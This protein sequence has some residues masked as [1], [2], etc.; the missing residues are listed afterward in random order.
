MFI[1][2][3][4]LVGTFALVDAA[5]GRGT[6]SKG[7]EAATTLARELTEQARTMSYSELTPALLPVRLQDKPGLADAS[8]TAP[9][10]Q[11][12]RRGFD[13]TVAVAVCSLDDPSDKRG[14]HSA[15]V[16]CA[17][18]ADVGTDDA[19]P[20]DLKRVTVTTSFSDR[21]RTVTS[22]S[23][24]TLNS[25]GQA[26]GLPVDTL[27]LGATDPVSSFGTPEE[28]VIGSPVNW[29][30]FRA[31]SST[32][33]AKVIWTIEGQRGAPDATKINATTWEFRWA[34]STVS[35]GSYTVSAQAVDAKGEVGP[36]REMPVRLARN[37]PPAPAS[38][39]GGYNQVTRAGTTYPNAAEFDWPASSQRNI[40]GYRLYRGD[41]TLACPASAAIISV[42]TSCVDE[43]PPPPSM[44]PE[45]DAARTY[46]VVALYRDA[47]SVL[48]ETASKTK[49]IVPYSY[50]VN[51]TVDET[52]TH[53]L[54]LS[55]ST[56]NIG[57]SCSGTASREDMLD[58]QAGVFGTMIGQNV[59]RMFCSPAYPAEAIELL[60]QTAV[61]YAAF[62]GTNDR[63]QVTVTLRRQRGT[64]LTALGAPS[65]RSFNTEPAGEYAM[66]GI[67][68][69]ATPLA[70]GDRLTLTAAYNNQGGC[71]TRSFA[72]G[73]YN[74]VS[75]GR[76]ALQYR[77]RKTVTRTDTSRP[78]PPTGLTSTPQPDGT[79]K[80]TWNKP[81]ATPPYAFYRIYADGIDWKANRITTAAVEPGA[82]TTD[83]EFVPGGA[84][85]YRITAVSQ[86]MT[87]SDPSAPLTVP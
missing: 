80:L 20:E 13:L 34:V 77:Y 75:Y 59:S 4:G 74:G 42:A 55:K 18:S 37:T 8:A 78:Q 85:T 69:P 39:Q 9:G 26:S 44:T 81:P 10:W 32:S 76:L 43:N 28:P 33:A 60:P 73:V 29:L 70:A 40:E 52:R 57:T 3:V 23:V 82:G 87:E 64:T 16:F 79:T 17:D 12:S 46:R 21:G 19:S 62:S 65:S 58:G 47:A 6:A 48:R 7:R 68:V 15:A 66:P 41:G 51:D 30:V 50:T 25:T 38:L 24:S 45:T 31:T 22:R 71:T 56:A 1:L 84:R 27:V 14:N 53:D 86:D 72:Y 11:V 83:S 36:P 5:N 67:A 35:D 63:C 2:M 54:R 49:K 61:F